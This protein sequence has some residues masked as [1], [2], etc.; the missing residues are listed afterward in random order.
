MSQ[1]APVKTNDIN[2]FS[3]VS[4]ADMA[5]KKYRFAKFF[6]TPPAGAQ[7][8]LA[9]GICDADDEPDGILWN[10]P[11]TGQPGTIDTVGRL[12]IELGASL[13][14]FDEVGPDA[15]GKAV[16]YGEGHGYAKIL[17]AGADGEVVDC[18]W[19][20]RR[21]QSGT[22]EANDTGDTFNAWADLHNITTGAGAD[23][24]TLPS[25]KYVGQKKTITVTTQG[26][27][28]Y[29]LSGLFTSGGTNTTTATFNAAGDLLHLMWNGSRWAV[30]LNTSV[31]LS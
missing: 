22:V 12:Y 27:G 8:R 26:A 19:L 3:A 21:R 16:L 30:I 7:D 10:G 15:N 2:P 20:N 31:T 13:S 14:A 1:V 18:V 6:Q 17:K 28:T 23:T 4:T 9:F 5:T 11:D 29:A 25:G 24:G